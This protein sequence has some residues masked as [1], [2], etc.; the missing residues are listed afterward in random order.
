MIHFL[1]FDAVVVS[2]SLKFQKFS[3][4]LE[5]ELEHVQGVYMKS[6]VNLLPLTINAE[7]KN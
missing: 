3:L 1:E 2:V 5:L 7:I 6:D 4:E